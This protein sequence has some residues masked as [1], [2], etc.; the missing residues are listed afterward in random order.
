MWRQETQL[1]VRRGL[2]QA[3]SRLTLRQA[4]QEWLAAAT[5]G[6]VRTRSGDPYKPSAIRTYGWALD[7]LYRDLGQQRLSNITRNQLQDL[8]DRLVAQGSSPSTVRNTILPLRAIYRRAQQRGEVAIDHLAGQVDEPEPFEQ[9]AAVGLER[10]PVG[11]DE[12]A[13][14]ALHRLALHIG[15]EQFV[16]RDDQRWVADD[17][18]PPS[19]RWVSFSN[20]CM[21]SFVRDLAMSAS[22][23]LAAWV[24]AGL[25][26]ANACS[27]DRCE[28]QTSRLRM[29]A[30]A[31]VAS[32]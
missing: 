16:D 18:R 25:N 6:V 12:I 21:L 10:A 22:A 26:S 15:R 13:H 19:T 30:K 1:A 7:K 32:R 8:A 20:A 2:A 28:Y 9:V 14:L 31:A 29:P 17:P 4:G 27:S 3:P 24:D 5:S 23:F 11:A